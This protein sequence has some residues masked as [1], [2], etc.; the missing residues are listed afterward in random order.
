MLYSTMP[1]NLI[2]P[3]NLP[4]DKK[5]EIKQRSEKAARKIDLNKEETREIIDEHLHDA[6][7]L[8]D[9]KTLNFRNCKTLPEKGKNRA[10][11]EWLVDGKWADYAL[12]IDE[13]LYGI[14]EAKR[15]AQDISTDLR[16]SKVYAERV[17]ADHEVKLLGQWQQYKVPFLFSTNGRPY[18]E[19]IKTKS[20]IWFLNVRS[21]ENRAYPPQSW[22]SPKGLKDLYGQNI[23]QSTDKLKDNS[24]DFLK[25]PAGLGLRAYQIQAIDKIEETIINFPDRKKALIAMA[26]GTGKT[27]TILGLCHR[28]IKANRF[29]RIL[30]LIDRTLLG[31]QAE[32]TFTD[33]K[34]EDLNTFSE[35]YQI[36]GMKVGA[37]NI[38]T[39]PHFA[40]VQSMVKRLFYNDLNHKFF[41]QSGN[42]TE[43]GKNDTLTVDT[44]DCII[45]DEAHRG[46][47][48][49]KEIDEEDL[50]CKNQL[51]YVSKYR[52]VLD[53]FDAYKIGLTA[54][55][56]LHTVEIFG[57]PVFNYSY[58]EAVIDGYLIDHESPY[59]IKTKLGEEGILWER[60]EK[61]LAYDKETN[62]ILEL[63][64]LEAE[65]KI[66]VEGFNRLVL[67]ENFNRTVIKE[68]VHHLDPDENAKTLV[69]AATDEHADL[70]VQLFKEEFENINLSVGDDAIAKITGKSFNVKE[71][72]K[73]Y[74]NEKHPNIAVTVDLLTTGIDVP[75]I[76]NLVFMRR[77]KS[78]IL[79]EQMLGRA[80]RLCDDIGKETFKIFDAVKMY[81]AL[82]EF[83]NM[84]PILP[85]PAISFS[86]LVEEINHIQTDVRLKKQ[87]D[88]I[89]AKLQR[90][91]KKIAGHEAEKFK[92]VAKGKD[93]D[94]FINLLRELTL[95]LAA[96]EIQKSSEVWKY[97]DDFKAVYVPQLWSD[98]EDKLLDVERG[99]GK[100][101]K[102]EDYIES[103]RAFIKENI[104]KIAAINLICTKPTELDRKSLKEL[105][106]ALDRQGFT[107]LNLREAW[108]AA[109][110][111][112]IAADIIS[113][114]RTMALGSTLIDHET[115]I[116]QAMRK[117]KASRSWNKV[118][119][120]WLD[121]FENQLIQE[122]ILRKE[123]LDN[124]PFREAGGYQK[125]N[126]IFEEDLEN[127]LEDINQNLYTETA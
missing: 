67:T 107:H 120:K 9:T 104:N 48:M 100:A 27:R 46:Y 15:Y 61:P 34:I 126:K 99:Y 7:W 80:T 60:G 121:R 92:Y 24:K 106:L 12:F 97:L 108:K 37:P 44:Y 58:R 47:L 82:E 43:D 29:K 72:V 75:A 36:E 83:T 6:G 94:E 105:Y 96:E 125:L 115:R 20:G 71:L 51:D 18:L 11:A 41:V 119:Q 90:K 19:Q 98:H 122:T 42:G 123:D 30:F 26:T 127:I 110:N 59:L 4:E 111:E 66:E 93:A 62:E 85:N 81:E 16:Q 32:G 13:Q 1:M 64:E 25:S 14:V 86:E 68:L 8:V 88:Q 101:K 33:S 79:Y 109:K 35:I 2:S 117:I 69:F 84:K 39:R 78:R 102:P 124:E 38:D 113:F 45:I 17:K 55:P 112:E 76:C 73:R 31:K 53:Y 77:V 28:L 65:L 74:K 22:Y 23:Q 103:F 57:K 56:A 10:I 50:G 89:V 95:D 87:I 21:P 5:T 116:R 3:G 118:R 70:I 49:D 40:T 91:K 63:D 54:T 114:I 52:M